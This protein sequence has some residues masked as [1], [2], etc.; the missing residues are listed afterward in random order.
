MI[1]IACFTKI[2]A[3][4]SKLELI[5]NPNETNYAVMLIKASKLAKVAGH[6]KESTQLYAYIFRKMTRNSASTLSL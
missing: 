3:L 4:F 5:R 2:D 6:S 1:T